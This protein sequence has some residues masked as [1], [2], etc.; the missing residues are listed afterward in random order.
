M[1]RFTIRELVLITA[2]VALAVGWTAVQRVLRQRIGVLSADG[3]DQ[4]WK[5]NALVKLIEQRDGTVELG[6]E[7]VSLYIV[8][9][10][11]S[12]GPG[13]TSIERN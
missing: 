8:A 11:W 7:F 4:Q 2:I 6:D 1:F 9:N 12:A 3:D 5:L 13:W 10:H